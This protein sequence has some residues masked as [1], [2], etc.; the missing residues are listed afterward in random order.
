MRGTNGRRVQGCAARDIV[1]GNE[2][3]T[4]L[5]RMESIWAAVA[6]RTKWVIAL[7]MQCFALINHKKVSISYHYSQGISQVYLSSFSDTGIPFV[8]RCFSLTK[9]TSNIYT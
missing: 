4:S 7:T 1:S 3:A 2:F 6:T 5:A 8:Y 9:D